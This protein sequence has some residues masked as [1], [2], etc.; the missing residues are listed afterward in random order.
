MLAAPQLHGAALGRSRP[1]A[2]ARTDR[3]HPQT[4]DAPVDSICPRL[5]VIDQTESEGDY[6]IRRQVAPVGATMI[7]HSTESVSSKNRNEGGFT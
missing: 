1:H 7:T 6:V 5:R 2:F 4:V 3:T